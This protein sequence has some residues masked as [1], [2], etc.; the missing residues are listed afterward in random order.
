[1]GMT[2]A[3]QQASLDGSF[4]AA[5]DELASA[6]AETR[7]AAAVSA[8]VRVVS[9]ALCGLF[10]ELTVALEPAL[11][12]NSLTPRPAV[13]RVSDYVNKGS[14]RLDD[15]IRFLAG[16]WNRDI[17]LV[18]DVGPGRVEVFLTSWMAAKEQSRGLARFLDA[19]GAAIREQLLELSNDLNQRHGVRLHLQ[20]SIRSGSHVPAARGWLEDDSDWSVWRSNKENQA[21]V[22]LWLVD[23]L[24]P[25]RVLELAQKEVAPLNAA[26]LILGG[27]E[28]RRLAQDAS[29]DLD[30]AVR[31][32]TTDAATAWSHLVDGGG[33]SGVIRDTAVGLAAVLA[34]LRAD[35]AERELRV[36]P[37]VRFSAS[38][39]EIARALHAAA[40]EWHPPAAESGLTVGN[41]G[42]HATIGWGTGDA[43]S[44]RVERPDDGTVRLTFL[45]D[46]LRGRFPSNTRSRLARALTARERDALLDLI[47]ASGGTLRPF[48]GSSECRKRGRCKV[49]ST[50]IDH[51][52]VGGRQ[53]SLEWVFSSDLGDINWL[54][55]PAHLF[56]GL[57]LQALP[58]PP[59]LAV[60][61]IRSES[62]DV[63]V[64]APGR[65]TG[66]AGRRIAAALRAERLSPWYMDDHQSVGDDINENTC[67]G[68]RRSRVVLVV[69]HDAYW[70]SPY[71]VAEFYEAV[72]R[73]RPLVPLAVTSDGK[74]ETALAQL[75]AAEH[76][77][78]RFR[79]G[80][81]SRIV[82]RAIEEARRLYGDTIRATVAADVAALDGAALRDV[83]A[84]IHKVVDRG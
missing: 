17:K 2:H 49:D 1:M 6:A 24:I 67:E 33:L 58:H 53:A 23:G 13:D 73:N 57:L 41:D 61:V 47:G 20:H 9:D 8:E 69:L 46:V 83:A 16:R 51:C 54:A 84:S 5:M 43:P 78:R 42:A 55:A 68:I 32:A 77:L 22:G 50:L 80:Q 48:C 3:S 52:I 79:D 65:E 71:C 60:P 59:R 11:G 76:G 35:M 28:G 75:S 81:P 7:G 36:L 44:I 74:A 40:V 39:D 18:V 19:E 62:W 56:T 34:R 4:F 12:P 72:R 27:L 30:A 26:G 31:R 64:S 37:S 15:S 45:T 63:F 25:E 38:A 14:D 21:A 70:G 10:D 29:G 66:F 82:D